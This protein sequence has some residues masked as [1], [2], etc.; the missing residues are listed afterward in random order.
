M[1]AT[2]L[3]LVAYWTATAAG[4]I[5][6]YPSAVLVARN[7]SFVALDLVAAGTGLAALRLLRRHGSGQTLQ[8][9]SLALTHAA[10]LT[11]LTFWVIRGEY[12]LGWWL[13][14]QWLTLFPVIALAML[15]TGPRGSREHPHPVRALC[16]VEDWGA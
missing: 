16:R 6:P 3:G 5:P 2:D 1:L 15:A 8:V 12:D 9:V 10:G 13:P 4:L 7:W 11:G 14:N